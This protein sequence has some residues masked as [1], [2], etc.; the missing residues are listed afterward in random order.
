T[1]RAAGA[2]RSAA[3][4][5]QRGERRGDAGARRDKRRTAGPGEREQTHDARRR[6]RREETDERGDA[7]RSGRGDQR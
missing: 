2:R 3:P 5:A 7:G 1:R 6:D 4:E